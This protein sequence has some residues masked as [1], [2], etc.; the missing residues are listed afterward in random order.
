MAR[1]SL[2]VALPN[3]VSAFGGRYA[4]HDDWQF[5]DTLNTSF[6]YGDNKLISLE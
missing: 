1:W 6:E 4:Y 5:Y 2:G 3:R